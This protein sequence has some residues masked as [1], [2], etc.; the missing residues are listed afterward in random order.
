METPPVTNTLL[1]AVLLG[2]SNYYEFGCRQSTVRRR[3]LA[4]TRS[5]QSEGYSAVRREHHA[6]HAF[7]KNPVQ[8]H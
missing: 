1:P 7:R 8:T 3:N 4:P 6:L 5:Y 2:N